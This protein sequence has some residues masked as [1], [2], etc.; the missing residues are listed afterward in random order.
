MEKSVL[1]LLLNPSSPDH[2]KHYTF[3][4]I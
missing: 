2:S 1:K 4:A 3:Q